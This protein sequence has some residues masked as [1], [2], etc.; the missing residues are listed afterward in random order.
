MT[1][2]QFAA[3]MG[4]E[5]KMLFSCAL[6]RSYRKALGIPNNIQK[7]NSRIAK[8]ENLL[9]EIRGLVKQDIV[10]MIDDYFAP[11]GPPT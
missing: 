9:L 5:L 6:V 3:F 4:Q 1:D 2:T 8:A 7:E 10:D 11:K